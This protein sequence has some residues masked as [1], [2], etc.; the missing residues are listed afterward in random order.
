VAEREGVRRL[1]GPKRH[2]GTGLLYDSLLSLHLLLLL[3]VSFCF[4]D[5]VHL[6]LTL[7]V[8]EFPLVCYLRDF[9]L[10]C[11]SRSFKI[12]SRTAVPLR[13]MQFLVILM[14]SE[15]RL[16]HSD[17]VLCAFNSNS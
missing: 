4:I 10:F 6:L 8:F 13:Q 9:P 1:F 11:V 7:L 12:V 3:F 5:L 15:G 14:F 2:E 16:S 17:L